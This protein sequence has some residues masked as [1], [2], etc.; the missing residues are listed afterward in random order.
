MAFLTRLLKALGRFHASARRYF[1]EQDPRFAVGFVPALLVSIVL[2]VRSP[3]SNYIFDEQEALLA[4]PYVND[5]KLPF[6]S[7]FA[8]NRSFHI[9]RF[10]FMAAWCHVG[11]NSPPP[12]MLAMT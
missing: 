2:Y 11:P 12:R 8:R 5:D 6:L 3:L 7:A 9:L 10:A 1:E 4:N